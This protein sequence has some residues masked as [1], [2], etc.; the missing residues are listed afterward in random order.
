ME[1]L[2]MQALD[3][4]VRECDRVDCIKRGDDAV[5]NGM[6]L[7]LQRSEIGKLAVRSMASFVTF[8]AVAL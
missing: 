5:A 6:Q 3:L 2:R 7:S 8:D 4:Q 1:I